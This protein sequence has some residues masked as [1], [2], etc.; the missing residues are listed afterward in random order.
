MPAPGCTTLTM[1]R[2]IINAMVLGAFASGNILQVLMFAVL[3][4]FALH[5]LG[6]K[7]QLIFNL[8]GVDCHRVRVQSRGID[9]HARAGLHYVDDDKTDNRGNILQVL[10]FAVLFGF[11]LHRLG[12]KGQLIFNVIESWIQVM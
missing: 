6:S 11:A 9:V 7:G 12:S 1:I 3:F 8:L 4:G 10:M 5:R 2:P